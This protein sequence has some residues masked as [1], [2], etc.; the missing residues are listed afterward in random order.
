MELLM[1]RV[2]VCLFV[3]GWKSIIPNSVHMH[4]MLCEITLEKRVTEL[5]VLLVGLLEYSI[6]LKKQKRRHKNFMKNWLNMMPER[7]TCD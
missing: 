6:L 5:N 4:L 1:E 7:I 2:I 3:V